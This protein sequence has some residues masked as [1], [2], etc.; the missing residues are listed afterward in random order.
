MPVITVDQKYIIK[1]SP[2][3]LQQVSYFSNDTQSKQVYTGDKMLA[4]DF[5][6]VTMVTT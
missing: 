4:A 3:I 2:S 5:M 1:H 6:T